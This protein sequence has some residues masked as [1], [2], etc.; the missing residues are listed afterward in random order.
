ME[1]L[2]TFYAAMDKI[3]KKKKNWQVRDIAS[4]LKYFGTKMVKILGGYDADGEAV[5]VADEDRKFPKYYL[6]IPP[7]E[8]ATNRHDIKA[9]YNCLG[10]L[11]DSIV[12]QNA[13]K[14]K[15]KP[16]LEFVFVGEN[17]IIDTESLKDLSSLSDKKLEDWI[18]FT[19]IPSVQFEESAIEAIKNGGD[20]YNENEEIPISTKIK[21]TYSVIPLSDFADQLSRA[22]FKN[23]TPLP[24]QLNIKG[25]KIKFRLN[26][27]SVF[28]EQSD[29]L[30][31][32]ISSLIVQY[33]ISFSGFSK[34]NTCEI[35]NTLYYSTRTDKTICGD[36]SCK[37][38]RNE[39]K[40]PYKAKKK[41]CKLRHNRW[42]DRRIKEKLG[43]S[44]GWK[45]YGYCEDCEIDP[46]PY[47]G[48]CPKFKK[49]YKVELEEF[50][51][52]EIADKKMKED[53]RE[54][55]KLLGSKSGGVQPAKQ[56]K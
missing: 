56:H 18:E 4:P 36:G 48:E 6:K 12:H 5:F 26:V 45:D 41:Q 10:M 23:T 33:Y 55:K 16:N 51:E 22:Y 3:V 34:I 21:L 32:L 29:T 17:R 39:K 19:K 7:Y 53:K 2:L 50:A 28:N 46:L 54:W 20:Q 25:K 38:I 1:G 9:I 52:W 37:A 8:Y 14:G 35:C 47:A 43:K 24:K 27:P 13:E 42:Y 11:R 30:F 31:Q 15:A 40:A 44:F 49:E